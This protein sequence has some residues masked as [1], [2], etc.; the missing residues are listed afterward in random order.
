MSPT[1][2]NK[3]IIWSSKAA[4]IFSVVVSFLFV[5]ATL[6][7]H[8]QISVLVFWVSIILFGGGGL[9]TLR[10]VINPAYFSTDHRGPLFRPTLEE[11]IKTNE[12]KFGNFT[13]DTGGVRLLMRSGM[14]YL[15]WA[16][17]KVIF[18][19]KVS[20]Y[21]DRSMVDD[22]QL[23]IFTDNHIPVTVFASTPGWVQFLKRLGE[24]R[25][26]IN[27]EWLEKAATWAVGTDRTLLLNTTSK[28]R[29]ELEADYYGLKN[30]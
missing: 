22:L 4:N 10:E 8:Q 24:N 19:S 25:P 18:G 17:I 26:T 20:Y 11:Q 13:Y 15:P 27:K 12:E 28:T 5:V 23:D 1:Y 16:D 30:E 6:I 7:V 14:G 9:A 3:R 29:E 2:K 21:D